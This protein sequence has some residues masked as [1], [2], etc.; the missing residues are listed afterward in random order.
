MVVV[1][2]RQPRIANVHFYELRKYYFI[3]QIDMCALTKLQIIQ[4]NLY[5]ENGLLGFIGTACT[6]MAQ[7]DGEKRDNTKL[8][9]Y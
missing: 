6:N 3:I 2:A 4:W 7:T 1:F 9:T 5:G 8:Y